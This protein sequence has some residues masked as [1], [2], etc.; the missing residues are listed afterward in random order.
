MLVIFLQGNDALV[1]N[2]F[3]RVLEV[4]EAVLDAEGLFGGKIETSIGS[5]PSHRHPTSDLNYKADI[6]EVR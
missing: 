3:K 5:R 4:L 6:Q 1:L 2:K